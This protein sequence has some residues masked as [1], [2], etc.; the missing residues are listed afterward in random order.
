MRTSIP[1]FRPLATASSSTD[2]NRF[3]SRMAAL[4]KSVLSTYVEMSLSKYTWT[5]DWMVSPTWTSSKNW[6]K[7][8]T[9]VVS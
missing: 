6:S 3:F 5:I 8:A 1:A 4:R 2:S 9:L 7:G